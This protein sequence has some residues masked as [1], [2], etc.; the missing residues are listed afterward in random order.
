MGF[1]AAKPRAG[2]WA[3]SAGQK[4]QNR[5]WCCSFSFYNFIFAIYV[6][7]SLKFFTQKLQEIQKERGKPIGKRRFWPEI[8]DFR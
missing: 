8:A 1:G 5:V 4:Q 3:P 7:I 2:N 6:R